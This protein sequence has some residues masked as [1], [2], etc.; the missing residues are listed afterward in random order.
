MTAAALGTTL[1]LGTLDG[2]EDIDVRPGT[3][4][5]HGDHRCAP[6]AC[7]TCAVSAAATCTCTSRS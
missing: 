7:R 4:S 2:D 5:G 6:A 1:T 3:Q